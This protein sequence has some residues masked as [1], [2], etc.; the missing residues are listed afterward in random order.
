VLEPGI[1]LLSLLALLTALSATVG[2]NVRG[3]VVAV[4]AGAFGAVLLSTALCR[5][6]RRGLGPADRVT[7][8]RGVLAGG[9]A[10]LAAAGAP[11]RPG[12]VPVLVGLATAS[13]LLDAVDGWVARRSG[14]VSRLGAALDMEVDAFLILV[15]SIVVARTSGGWVLAIGAARYA[16]LAA[17]PL[18][19]WLRA[20]L[21]PRFWAKVV[22]AVTGVVLTVVA[23]GLLPSP[24][25]LVLLLVTAGL[26]AE[27][28]GR[29][30]LALQRLHRLARDT[31]DDGPEPRVPVTTASERDR[32]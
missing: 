32:G 29:Q 2:V 17:E 19:P 12:V 26:L 1:G 27:S 8:G 3:W 25:A 9:V 31:A 6:G 14:T 21:P 5:D 4:G 15:L 22:A 7:V 30:V 11:G 16:L 23:S 24:V 13:L 28:F 18:L 20:P 10:A